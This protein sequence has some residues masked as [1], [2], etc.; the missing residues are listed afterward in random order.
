MGKSFWKACRDAIELDSL[1]EMRRNGNRLYILRLGN[2]LA[3]IETRRCGSGYFYEYVTE[4]MD[5]IA[6][7]ITSKFQTLTYCGVSK[8]LLESF[9]VRHRLTGIDRIVPVGSAMDIGLIWDGYDLIRTLS[10]VC[11][12]R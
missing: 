11:D 5:D 10:R 6:P 2:L 8:E 1:I 7:I 9:V 12:I 4:N 3:G